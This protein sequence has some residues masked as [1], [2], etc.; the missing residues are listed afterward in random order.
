[1]P[2]G[3]R[4]HGQESNEELYSNKSRA[5]PAVT[6][7]IDPTFGQRSA[8]PLDEDLDIEE[9]DGEPRYDVEMDA[10]AYLKSVRSVI[11][12]PPAKSLVL[13]LLFF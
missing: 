11:L 13:R 2:G 9:E 1:M 3:K 6:A 12:H 7:R 5:R 8:I 4:K 10:L